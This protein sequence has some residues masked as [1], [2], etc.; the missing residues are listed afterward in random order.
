MQSR[1]PRPHAAHETIDLDAIDRR[2]LRELARDARQ[3]N[4]ALAKRVGLS[5]SACL[6]R[7]RSLEAKGVIRGYRSVLD[8]AATGVGLVAYLSVGLAEHGKRAQARFEA[9]V[10]AAPEVVECHDVTG[11]VEHPLRVE[12]ADLAAYKRLHTEGL[13]AP[14]E[15]RAPTSCV[16]IGSPKD[17]RA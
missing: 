9:A 8:P 17:G 16:V 3:S 7:V 4:A 10:A 12:A 2:I 15:V 11:A 14:P 13:G 1:A 6:R 5:A